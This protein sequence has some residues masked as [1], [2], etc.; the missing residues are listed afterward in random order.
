MSFKFLHAA[1]IH[2]DSPLRGL[3]RYDGVPLDLVRTATRAA[4][5][6]LVDLAI[7]EQVAFL[8]IAGDLY[9]GTWEAFATGLYFCKAVG[10]LGRAGIDVYLVYGNHD[11]ESHLTRQLPRPPNLH[12]FGTRKP[13]TFEH[14]ATGVL[15][16]GQS[17]AAREPGPNFAAGYPVG[18]S[19]RVNIGVLHT[20]LTGNPDHAPYAPCTPDELAAK[21]YSYW[22][23]GH[24]HAF[25]KVREDPHIVFPGNLQGRNIRETGA[26]G[27]AL[28]TVEDGRISAAD[29][30]PLDVVRWSVAEIDLTEA[31]NE[32]AIFERIRQG[33]MLA[34]A[35]ADGRPLMARVRLIGDSDLK[36][37]LLAEGRALR[38]RVRSVAVAI[39]DRIWIE[40]VE[41][42]M[43][44]ASRTSAAGDEFEA[45]LATAAMD[46]EVQAELAQD[47]AT[48]L[49]K[50]PAD[51]DAELSLL[52]HARAGDL[53]SVLE[54]ARLALTARLGLEGAT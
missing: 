12:V 2:L 22:A 33:L 3:P 17:Y 6:N 27:A 48:F 30:V 1:D 43:R 40:K 13:E 15:L 53:S 31:A 20:A 29:H 45:I 10:R 42:Q 47:L 28:V 44:A 39:S 19:G 25:S 36:A 14:D 8:I 52:A 7:E 34:E 9:D 49:N 50:A 24:V 5:D 32:E 18:V 46:A 37:V 41:L 38:E 21:G 51:L 54:D 16:H 26:K 11:A 23:L 35:R 4:F